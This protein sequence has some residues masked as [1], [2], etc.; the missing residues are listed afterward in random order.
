MSALEGYCGSAPTRSLH[1]VEHLEALRQVVGDD[2]D[3]A[4]RQPALRDEGDGGI[5]GQRLDRGR[6]GDVLGQ[7]EIVGP[8]CERGLGDHR[9]QIERRRTEHRELA[10]EELDQLQAVADID[11]DSVDALVAVAG[12]ENLRGTVDQGDVVVA[13]GGEQLGDCGADLAGSDHDDVLH[14]FSGR[15]SGLQSIIPKN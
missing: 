15:S 1:A 7:I 5:G 8:R 3:E 12:S 14:A 9:G 11:S 13:G 2:R 6:A 10:V 4:G